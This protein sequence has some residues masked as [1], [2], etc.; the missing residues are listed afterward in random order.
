MTNHVFI[1]TIDPG[2]FW[3][4]VECTDLVIS[5]GIWTVLPPLTTFAPSDFCARLTQIVAAFSLWVEITF[6]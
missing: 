2:L 3:R 6:W 5:A 4:S 1:K